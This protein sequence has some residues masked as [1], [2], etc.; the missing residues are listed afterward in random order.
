MES[1]C[2]V[3]SGAAGW[4]HTGPGV[5]RQVLGYDA[6]LMLVNVRFDKGG[7]GPLHQHPQR[8]VSFIVSGRF[9]V[10]IGEQTRVLSAGD[11]FLIPPG[12]THG[13]LALDDGDIVDVFAPA[14][15]DL[16][17]TSDSVTGAAR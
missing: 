15:A 7:V 4:E 10:Q 17:A 12:V 16:L 14:R 2:F 9:E 8:Q 6:D 1:E 5:S 3:R 11:C 13:V